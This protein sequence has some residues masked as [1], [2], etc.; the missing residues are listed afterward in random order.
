MTAVQASA[1]GKM[2]LLG[3]YAVLEH[4]P[5]LVIAVNRHARARVGM[6][7][8]SLCEVSAPDLGIQPV[9]FSLGVGGAVDWQAG[10]ADAARLALVEHTLRGLGQDGLAPPAGSALQLQLDT[11]EF[12]DGEGGGKLG[13]GS[14]AALT[15]ALASALAAFSGHGDVLADRSEWLQRMLWLHRQLQDGRGSGADVAASL[16]GGLIAY[17]LGDDGRAKFE[18]LAWPAGVHTLFVWTGSSASTGGFLGRLAQWRSTHAADYDRHLDELTAIAEAAVEAVRAG[19]AADLMA[20]AARYALALEVFG[21]ACGLEIFS[22]AHRQLAALLHD[23]GVAYKPCGAGG[24]DFGMV[25]ALDPQALEK[26]RRRIDEAGFRCVALELE[27]DG[28]NL[29]YRAAQGDARGRL[30]A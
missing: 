16:V 28:L 29:E 6:R 5:A 11:A 27:G 18:R 12:F 20:C 30:V 14:S 9:R 3:E 13:L 17:R 19:R 22:L 24:G 15:V 7:A 26:A 1:P 21:T 23:S 4:A 10:A 2:F 8:G 25:F